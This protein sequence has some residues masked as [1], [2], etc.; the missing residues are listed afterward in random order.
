VRKHHGVTCSEGCWRQP[1][2]PEASPSGRKRRMQPRGDDSAQVVPQT[3]W[4]PSATLP[5]GAPHGGS[6]S[7]SAL[8][9]RTWPT[10]ISATSTAA[11]TTTATFRSAS[12][13]SASP[14]RAARPSF[15]WEPRAPTAPALSG[16]AP[17]TVSASP[18]RP[19]GANVDDWGCR[20]VL[21]M[22]DRNR[23]ASIQYASRL[24]RPE[25]ANPGYNGRGWRFRV[26]YGRINWIVT[27]T[28]SAAQLRSAVI[29][30][31]PR[32]RPVARQARSPRER[33]CT[34]VSGRR[35]AMTTAS[36]S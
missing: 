20:S 3:R 30:G 19:A 5:V 16:T 25:C 31:R 22:F 1:R 6:A 34:R 4:W 17:Q 7:G 8:C 2:S 33:P 14:A 10:A 11:S 23:S 29:T 35:R 36:S 28:S 15:P 32:R 27:P 9:G 12:R 21:R 24:A 13:P 18:P 26:R